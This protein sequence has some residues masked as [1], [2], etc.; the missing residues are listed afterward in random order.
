MAQRRGRLPITTWTNSTKSVP[1][2]RGPGWSLSWC[3]FLFNEDGSLG[4]QAC[5]FRATSLSLSTFRRAFPF[6]SP[7]KR[8]KRRPCEVER[9]SAT[10]G[11]KCKL[12]HLK[13]AGAE[14]FPAQP[15][16]YI[17]RCFGGTCGD[18]H[19]TCVRIGS[20]W[21]ACRFK[22]SS[23]LRINDWTRPLPETQI[24]SIMHHFWQIYR[25][26]NA[27]AKCERVPAEHLPS[28]VLL[29]DMLMKAF[30]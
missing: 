28:V 8:N 15:P 5:V 6:I 16:D 21:N 4:R 27:T 17:W 25:A 1:F 30:K 19:Q 22:T 12:L 23:Y 11:G 10:D 24:Q 7:S 18:L 29:N 9:K 2:A 20:P 26:I 13:K 14:A 3:H